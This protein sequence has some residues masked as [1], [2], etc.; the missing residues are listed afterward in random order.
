MFDILTLNSISKKIYDVLDD[1]YAVSDSVASPDAILVRSF[2]MADYAIPDNLLAVAR[3]GAGVNNIPVP[4]MTDAGV[5]VFNTP[6]ANANGV[7]ELVLCAMLLASRDILGGIDWANGLTGDD[8][9]KQVEKGKSK[10][11]GTELAGKTVGIVG[12]GAI[13]GKVAN[14]C[15]ALGMNVVVYDH[16]PVK[17]KLDLLKCDYTLVNT[18]EDVYPLA[19]YVTLHVPA[20]DN[21]KGM[22][23]AETLA[24]FK[25]GAI[26]IN[27]ARAELA[28]VNAVKD[29]LASGKLRKYVVD[30]PT[31]DAL[32]SNGIIAI[33]HLGA[34]TEESE[35]NCAVMAASQLRDYLENGNIKNSV[36][37]PALV[38]P[39]EKA[40]RMTIIANAGADVPAKVMSTLDE[41][42]KYEAHYAER[43]TV[44]YI[45]VDTDDD[46]CDDTNHAVEAITDLDDIVSI[47]LM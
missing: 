31:P 4:R 12:L 14:A 24:R 10:F 11:A 32:R 27:L 30:F 7:K 8:V 1:N 25:D 40:H 28:D 5:C 3:A 46:L 37:F 15:A 42:I 22:I 26:L 43:G 9:A 35:D 23:N 33:P 38:V 44:A 36:N 17:E 19:D 2:N 13:G 34:S 18:P 6:G 41:H 20:K 16:R 29:A 47:R 45:I 21:T 39:R